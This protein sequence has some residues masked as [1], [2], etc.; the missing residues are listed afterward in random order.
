MA[1]PPHLGRL[2]VSHYLSVVRFK[3]A[4]NEW[5]PFL[6]HSLSR[7]DVAAGTLFLT[8]NVDGQHQ[9]VQQNLFH[10]PQPHL[11]WYFL[12]EVKLGSGVGE[13]SFYHS[14]LDAYPAVA[15]GVELAKQVEAGAA[16]GGGSPARIQ[17]T[18]VGR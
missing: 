8:P 18:I 5:R 4:E 17:P 10:P 1:A 2:Q 6:L 16:A 11:W 9:W 7:Q 13:W 15:A 3:V 14:E 12:P